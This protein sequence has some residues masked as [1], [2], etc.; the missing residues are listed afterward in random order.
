V[1]VGLATISVAVLVGALIT[2][3][4]VAKVGAGVFVPDGVFVVFGTRV[5]VSNDEPGVRNTP[6]QAGRV[7]MDE[8]TGP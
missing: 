7:R 8:S 3:G 5:C 4:E 6:N 2:V 1:L